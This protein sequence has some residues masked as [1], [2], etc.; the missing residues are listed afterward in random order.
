V[1]AVREALIA[2]GGIPAVVS[3]LGARI[4]PLT[5]A[6]LINLVISEWESVTTV[7]YQI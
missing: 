7:R 3:S 4:V 6:P 5:G 2:V 1:V